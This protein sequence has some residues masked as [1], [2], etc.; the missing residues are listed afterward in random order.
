[1]CPPFPYACASFTGITVN[2]QNVTLPPGNVAAVA[3][4]TTLIAGPAAV[5]S[6]IYAQIPGSQPLSG[7]YA[8]YYGFR[9]FVF[10]LVKSHV[11]IPSS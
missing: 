8:G 9:M 10:L 4:S 6:A 3:T 2:N 11:D 5:I 1:M 7:N